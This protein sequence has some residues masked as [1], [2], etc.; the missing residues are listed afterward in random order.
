MTTIDYV[1]QFVTIDQA[2]VD[3]ISMNFKRHRTYTDPQAAFRSAAR[4]EMLGISI[5][6]AHDGRGTYHVWAEERPLTA[7]AIIKAL[8]DADMPASWE[9]TGGGVYNVVVDL[10]AAG[11]VQVSADGNW[12]VGDLH[13]VADEV[14]VIG[15]DAN[16]DSVVDERSDVE[17]ATYISDVVAT[18]RDMA[19]AVRQT[20]LTCARCGETLQITS[21]GLV[22]SGKSYCCGGFH[23]HDEHGTYA[24]DHTTTVDDSAARDG[25]CPLC[26]D[27]ART[28][29][30]TLL[31][32]YDA[33]VADYESLVADEARDKYIGER[34]QS[35]DEMVGDLAEALRAIITNGA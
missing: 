27:K 33:L 23:G 6:M 4:T 28:T 9:N 29:A 17:V 35:I 12:G 11:T 30:R 1:K 7:A 20:P 24:P 25:D 13:A 26:A 31:A 34:Q 22:D 16:G 8:T 19:E 3:A 18:A 5:A 15:Y 2:S 21:A 32:Q 14:T 10:G